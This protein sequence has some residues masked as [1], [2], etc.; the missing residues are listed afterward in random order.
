[1]AVVTKT[2]GTATRDYSTM[3]LWEADLD[4][5]GIYSAGD[6]AVGECYDDSQF[7]ELC[8]I[9]GGRTVGLSTVLLTVAVGERHDG[10]SAGSG[11]NI[12]NPSHSTFYI[13]RVN[14]TVEWLKSVYVGNGGDHAFR[15]LSTADDSVIR[16]CYSLQDTSTDCDYG[17]RIGNS[18]T[19]S[20]I[21]NCMAVSGNTTDP[22]RCFM[23][24]EDGEFLNCTAWGGFNGFRQD[25]NDS[26]SRMVI[27]NCIAMNATSL[28]FH[29]FG[30]AFGVWGTGTDYNLSDDGYAPG[31]NSLINKD[32]TTQ[33]VSTVA[34]SEDLHLI[35]GSDAIGA[36]VDLGTTPTNIEFDIDNEDRTGE[37][38]DIGGDQ[39]LSVGG[40]GFT[41]LT[42]RKHNRRKTTSGKRS[43]LHRLGTK[44]R[45]TS[46]KK[47]IR[48]F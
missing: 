11:A 25:G 13:G 4:D 2:I 38:W 19:G 47:G 14:T 29:E 10:T 48:R 3:G 20:A 33:F 45:G 34:A 39:L 42:R 5:A 40:G 44:V 15:L 21:I 24:N 30:S 17:Y 6:D 18:T 28:T 43:S 22:S 41:P 23:G 32:N 36:G 37:V 1:M 46:N 31:G 7:S 16:N 12:T 8:Y 27:K 9:N 35:A 26:G